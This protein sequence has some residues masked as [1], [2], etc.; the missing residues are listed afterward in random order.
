MGHL[1]H[2]SFT[3]HF[4]VSSV[5]TLHIEPSSGNCLTYLS[6]DRIPMPQDTLQGD[7]VI[8][9]DIMHVEPSKTPK[10]LSICLNNSYLG[11]KDEAACPAPLWY[12]L[13]FITTAWTHTGLEILSF[14][15][16]H[17]EVQLSFQHPL[18]HPLALF[19]SGRATGWPGGP[20]WI[21]ACFWGVI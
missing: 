9:S 19:T 15:T 16:R 14:W 8:H 5:G 7:H 17:T 10:T 3:I 20:V 1:Q 2:S 13:T 12:F 21:D 6:L 18:S 4:S 11:N